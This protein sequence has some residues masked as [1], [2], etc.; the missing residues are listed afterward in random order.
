MQMALCGWLI[1]VVGIFSYRRAHPQAHPRRQGL[2]PRLQ[3]VTPYW[4]C[5]Q[6]TP[7]IWRVTG[8]GSAAT[9]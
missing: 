6:A 3:V 4:I 1:V 2:G 9:T 7:G 8:G 5:F